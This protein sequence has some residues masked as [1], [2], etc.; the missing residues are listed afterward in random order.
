MRLHPTVNNPIPMG[1]VVHKVVTRDGANLRALNAPAPLNNAKGTIVFVQGRAD[2]MERYFESMRTAQD[3]KYAVASFDFRGQGGS[4]RLLRN[5]RRGHGRRFSDYDEDLRSVMTQ[6]VIPNCPKPYFVVAHSTGG[7]VLLRHLR[8][9]TDF[10]RAVVTA[11][12]L[13]FNYGSWPRWVVKL[14]TFMACSL[15]LSWLYIPGRKKSSMRREE[16]ARNTFTSDQQRY[17]RDVETI[18]QFPEV[19]LG[20]PTFGWLSAA[21][22]SNAELRRWPRKRPVSCPT[23]IVAAGRERIVDDKA[24]REFSERVAGVS[25]IEIKDSKHEILMESD[26]IRKPFWKAA[27]AFFNPP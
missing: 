24:A 10:T 9:R 25:Y 19:T 4:Q 13:E 2:F 17:E 20:G 6:V 16:F 23:L 14:L 8:N 22:A 12:L 26:T 21:F 3:M 7:N 18:E 5:P 11:P 27:D 1:A 15:M